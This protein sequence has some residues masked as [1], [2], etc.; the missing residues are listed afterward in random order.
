[1][2]TFITG[3]EKDKGQVVKYDDGAEPVED[4]D[5]A[6]LL[7]IHFPLN[8]LFFRKL[9]ETDFEINKDILY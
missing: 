2:H 1:M 5:C 6:A 7:F 9:Y 4:T 8:L 3:A